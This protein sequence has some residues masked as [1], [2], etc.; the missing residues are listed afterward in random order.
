MAMMTYPMIIEDGH[1][2]AK[3]TLRDVVEKCDVSDLPILS[4]VKRLYDENAK[5]R[6]R[7]NELLS[8]NQRLLEEVM[9]EEASVEGMHI[10]NDRYRADHAKLTEF[11]ED[12]YNFAYNCYHGVCEQ[13]AFLR[14]RAK[15]NE[16]RELGIEV[17]DA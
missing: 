3:V 15:R 1:L 11:A 8:S 16:L 7:I 2:Y 14:L 10:I 6:A 9:C 4:E 5:L 17:P 13:E 12:A